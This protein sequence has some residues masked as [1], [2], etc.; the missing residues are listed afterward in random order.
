MIAYFDSS[1]AVPLFVEEHGSEV[2]RRIWATA[3]TV[4]TTRLL[5][6]ETSAALTRAERLGRLTPAAHDVA[7]AGLDEIWPQFDVV[8]VAQEL[9]RQA[10]QLSREQNLRGF[11]AVHCAAGLSVAGP[12]TVALAGDRALLTAWRANGLDVVDTGGN[13]G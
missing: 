2:C 11:D 10:A 8:E 1:A 7:L 6:V 13:W 9:I 12:T 4:V 3:D 5:Y